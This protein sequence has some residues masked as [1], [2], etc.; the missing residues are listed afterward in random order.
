MPGASVS[1]GT[2][3]ADLTLNTERLESGVAKATQLLGGLNATLERV[4][5]QL[6]GLQAS[7]N[8]VTAQLGTLNTNL[9]GAGRQLVNLGTGAQQ[10]SAQMNVLN[11]GNI[12]AS[13]GVVNLGNVTNNATTVVRN[14]G[15]AA[16]QAAHGMNLFGIQLGQMATR[17]VRSL[18]VAGTIFAV[19]KLITTLTNAI[20]SSIQA[21]AEFEKMMASASV[22]LRA[23]ADES[24]QMADAAKKMGETTVFSAIKAAEGFRILAQAGLTARESII[25]LPQVVDF[26]VAANYDLAEATQIA[27][28]ALRAMELP[29]EQVSRVTDALTAA[30]TLSTISIKDISEAFTHSVAIAHAFGYS[31]EELSALIAILGESGIRGSLAGTQLAR[32]IQK[33]NEAAVQFKLPSADLIDVLIELQA[34]GATSADIMKLFGERGG[35]AAIE[36]AKA[37]TATRELQE[38]VGSMS[39]ETKR[40]ADVINNTLSAA[41]VRLG[42][43]IQVAGIEAFE[44]YKDKVRSTIDDAATWFQKHQKDI[45]GLIDVT[46]RFLDTLVRVLGLLGSVFTAVVGPIARVIEKI[47][48]ATDKLDKFLVSDSKWDKIFGPIVGTPGEFGRNTKVTVPGSTVHQPKPVIPR[49]LTSDEDDGVKKAIDT[50]KRLLDAQVR[51]NEEVLKSDV[52]TA[53]EREAAWEGYAKFRAQQI[54][55]IRKADVDAGVDMETA[56]RR[57]RVALGEMA[58]MHDKIFNE[59]PAKAAKK[60]LDANIKAY[61]E[62]LKSGT[63]TI[64]Q[65]TNVWDTFSKMRV[66]QIEAEAEAYI[67][68]NGATF[69]ATEAAAL[70]LQM[71]FDELHKMHQKVFADADPVNQWIERTNKEFGT[72]I[73]GIE[74]G[75]SSV[76]EQM[77]TEGIAKIQPFKQ[78]WLAVIREIANEVS[79]MFVQGA[80]RRIAGAVLPGSDLPLPG[81]GR[82]PG[83]GFTTGSDFGVGKQGGTLT[84]GGI[85]KVEMHI[86]TPDVVSFRASQSQIM[87]EAATRMS[88][89]RRNM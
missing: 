51:A 59:D 15:T 44:K 62:I 30:A 63:L 4:V 24:R 27:I 9:A 2:L 42:N 89:A 88:M 84:G 32:A 35:K 6:A 81:G 70:Q 40:Q 10:A 56:S 49:F 5:Q 13:S 61:E 72:M 58:Q 85:G 45:V 82:A 34:R 48:E 33:A 20:K 19:F 21:G 71:R 29:V 65:L 28:T 3:V 79:R 50:A 14:F 39:G 17:L 46:V 22:I 43:I 74:K 37:T 12:V 69:A 67:E 41:W 26:A 66:E 8:Q 64:D 55:A 75:F 83:D 78:A 76:F 25:A 54:E 16:Q 77:M 80:I 47:T 87:A 86:H 57:A 23:T 73:D 7:L 36:I 52:A 38:K 31:V 18:V 68:A 11:Q 53:R 1:L 60:I